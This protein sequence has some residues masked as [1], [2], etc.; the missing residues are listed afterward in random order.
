MNIQLKNK[1]AKIAKVYPRRAYVFCPW[2]E[3]S[4]G[5]PDISI[6]L[7]GDY[8]GCWTCW[9]CHQSGKITAEQLKRLR[10]MRKNK[11]KQLRE[12]DWEKLTKEYFEA[13]MPDGL[14]Q[15]E[16]LM[17]TQPWYCGWDGAAW[18]L[19]LREPDNTICGIQ[20]V[21]RDRRK[22]CVEGSRLGLMIPQ[23][24]FDPS[25]R[26]IIVEGWSDACY[27]LE[28][29]EQVIARPSA[30]SC[31]EMCWQWCHNNDI[32]NVILIPDNDEAGRR[33]AE[34]LALSFMLRSERC[35]HLD[36]LIVPEQFNDVRQFAEAKGFRRVEEWLSSKP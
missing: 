32:S 23:I 29:G 9:S 15:I 22:C 35:F 13:E 12:F 19:P 5:T 25:K 20:R 10:G 36:Q 3:S 18:T 16:K 24:E 6:D 33:G 7:E 34:E 14:S 26:I 21:F 8:S 30:S 31:K 27:I 4:K 1:T 17:V 11:P 28:T 2:H